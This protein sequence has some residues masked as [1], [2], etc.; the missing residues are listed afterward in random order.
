MNELS[1]AQFTD[2]ALARL[3]A[4]SPPAGFEAGLL[5]GYDGWRA[6]RRAGLAAVLAGAARGLAQ[7]VWPGA[8]AW[9]PAGA[10][11]L[12]L[13]LGAGLGAVLPGGLDRMVSGFSLDRTPGFTTLISSDGEEDL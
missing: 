8:P 4:V 7:L 5:A 3:P 2:R 13:L 6:R 12:A 1:D 9:A 10:L 11:T